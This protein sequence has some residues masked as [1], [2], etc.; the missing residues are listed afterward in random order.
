M[1]HGCRLVRHNVSVTKLYKVTFTNFEL[2]QHLQT[3]DNIIK[4]SVSL[5]CVRHSFEEGKHTWNWIKV[6]KLFRE[7]GVKR[8]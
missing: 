3:F 1:S 5:F 6:K 4:V 7:T 2:W 8:T